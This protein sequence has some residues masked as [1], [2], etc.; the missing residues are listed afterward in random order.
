MIS[1]ADMPNE[2]GTI[3]RRQFERITAH[4]EVR[5]HE[6]PAA[7]AE[8]LTKATGEYNDITA[9][10][11]TKAVKDVMSVVT[12]NISLG[13]LKIIGAKP[14]KEKSTLNLEMLIPGFPVPLKALAVVVRADAA[15]DGKYS[16][17]VLFIG[18]NKEDIAKV[19]RYV[20]L[21]KRAEIEKR[22]AKR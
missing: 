3:E 7:E 1:E 6:I 10:V 5:Y 19:E 16:A 22:N 18:L 14:F 17:G 2:Q 8:Q 9:P 21:M 15:V 20:L 4:F 12:E 13:G 11:A